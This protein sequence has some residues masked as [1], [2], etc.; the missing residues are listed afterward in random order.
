ALVFGTSVAAHRAQAQR[1][2]AAEPAPAAA[3]P[4]AQPAAPAAKDAEDKKQSAVSGR[5]LD[6]DGKPLPGAV[7]AGHGG[8][9]F[10]NLSVQYQAK[11]LGEVKTDAEGRFRIPLPNAPGERIGQVELLAGAKGYGL[12]WHRKYGGVR[13]EMGRPTP[14][15]EIELHLPAA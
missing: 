14:G 10:G 6:G 4:A 13:I 5:V 1:P 12:T 2:D 11:A 15:A 9:E 8:L 7:V 3:E